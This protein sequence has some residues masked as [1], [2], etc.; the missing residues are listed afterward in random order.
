MELVLGNILCDEKKVKV[1]DKICC[2]KEQ[3][4]VE[5]LLAS[6]LVCFCGG[7]ACISPQKNVK[8]GSSCLFMCLVTCGNSQT[9]GV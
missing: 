4:N 2:G 1:W 3:K 6:K 5:R 9:T 7:R 8:E